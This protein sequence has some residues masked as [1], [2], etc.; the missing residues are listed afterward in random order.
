LSQLGLVVP[1]VAKPVAAYVPAYWAIP[2]R[3]FLYYDGRPIDPEI[4]RTSGLFR[5]FK[6]GDANLAYPFALGIVQQLRRSRMTEVDVVVPIPLSPEKAARKEL[7][8][9]KALADEV[10]RLLS[11]PVRDLLTLHGPIGKRAMRQATGAGPEEFEAAYREQLIADSKAAEFGRILIVDD[12]CTEGSTLECAA[13]AILQIHPGA[14]VL[15]ATA[16]Q[17]AV[18]GVVGADV[19]PLFK[20]DS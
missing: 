1:D 18:R 17:M 15:T 16:A 11:A 4:L 7:H 5:R 19:S 10:G 12:V 6:V 8:R 9:A 2:P 14:T 20:H 3:S 13:E